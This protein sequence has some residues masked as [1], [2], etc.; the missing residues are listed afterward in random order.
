[1]LK[2]IAR[3]LIDC[4]VLDIPYRQYQVLA[5]TLV[6]KQREVEALPQKACALMIDTGNYPPGAGFP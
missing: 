2:V 5:L 6:N 4:L 3:L 1:L